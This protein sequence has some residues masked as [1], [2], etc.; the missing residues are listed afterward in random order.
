MGW[1]SLPVMGLI[2][3]TLA[4]MRKDLVLEWRG[5]YALSGILLYVFSTV[6]I[7]YTSFEEVEAK[8]W[9]TLFWVVLLFASISAIV[10]SFVQ[11]NSPRQLYYYSLTNPIAVIL[12]KTLYNIGLL[13]VVSLLTWACF[14]LMAGNA[15]KD[16][17]QF[18]L[19]L[20]LGSVG[21][22]IT[23]TF[24]AAIAGKADHSATLQAIMSFPLVLPILLTLIRLSANALRLEQDSSISDDIAILAGIDLLSLGMALLLFPFLWRE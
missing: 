1:L 2:K 8:A 19:A 3:E 12:S 24:V 15:V 23:F 7:I 14:A 10:K 9:N 5:K 18:F 4:L 21:L 17:S 13:M 22:S 6:F 11:E 16:N 20:F